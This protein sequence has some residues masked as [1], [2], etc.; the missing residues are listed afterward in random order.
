MAE[1][2]AVTSFRLRQLILGPRRH[3]SAPLPPFRGR[4]D[5]ILRSSLLVFDLTTLA[6]DFLIGLA[7]PPRSKAALSQE[8]TVS[9]SFNQ[10]LLREN[11]RAPRRHL[12]PE[13]NPWAT[14]IKLPGRRPV[15]T[16]LWPTRTLV[17]RRGLAQTRFGPNKYLNGPQR[18]KPTFPFP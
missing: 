13:E 6:G 16:R 5:P 10:R 11:L 3:I 12:L 14:R 15:H 17:T 7:L 1:P 18:L 8:P 2:A 4:T 9:S